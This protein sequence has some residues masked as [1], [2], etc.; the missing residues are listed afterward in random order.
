M[1]NTDNGDHNIE[2][3]IPYS[4]FAQQTAYRQI[5][6]QDGSFETRQLT[7]NEDIIISGESVGSIRLIMG[8]TKSKLFAQQMDCVIYSQKGIVMT[9]ESDFHELPELNGKIILSFLTKLRNGK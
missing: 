6:N 4:K 1:A 5:S 7:M 8:L 9:T 2:C 3:F